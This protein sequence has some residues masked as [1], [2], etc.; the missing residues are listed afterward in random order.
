MLE[1]TAPLAAL[2]GGS[3]VVYDITKGL[4]SVSTSTAQVYSAPI[5]LPAGE[6]AFEVRVTS[7]GTSSTTNY[8]T[9]RLVNPAGAEVIGYI[10]PA[11]NSWPPAQAVVFHPPITAAGAYRISMQTSST[12]PTYGVGHIDRIR[13]IRLPPPEPLLVGVDSGWA[14]AP[15]RE[16]AVSTGKTHETITEITIPMEVA[17]P[18]LQ[19]LFYEFYKLTSIPDMDTRQVT[20]MSFMFY[21]CRSLPAVPEMD[22]HL[23]TNMEG[24]FYGCSVLTSIPE[25]DTSQATNMRGM[26]QG[27]KVATSVPEL[28]TSQVTNMEAMFQL[29][30]ELTSIPDMD[31]SQVTNMSYMLYDCV[32]LTSVPELDT[33]RVA[34]MKGMFYECSGLTSIPDMN[35]SQVTDMSFM[36]YGC[37]L[38]TSVPELDTSRVTEIRDMFTY[39]TVLESVTLHGMGNGFTTAQTLDMMYTKMDAAAANSLMES[40]GTPPPGCTLRLPATAAGANTS[41]AAAKN[42]EVTIV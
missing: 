40:L 5:D 25:M 11:H 18:S 23:V 8:F 34:D 7:T 36:F 21:N 10:V 27:C 2:A 15:L 6:Y 20:D 4:P 14:D 33:S 35:T 31:T 1:L 42:W 32:A 12:S 3:P 16:W 38:L 19:G 13:V 9:I 26:F 28:D 41:I 17:G 39:C 22:T 30:F 29:C 24:M 37:R